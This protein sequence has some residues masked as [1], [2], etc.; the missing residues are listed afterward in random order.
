MILN[1]VAVLHSCAVKKLQNQSTFREQDC[2]CCHSF[3]SFRCNYLELGSLNRIT[4]CESSIEL[5]EFCLK[6][7]PYTLVLLSDCTNYV[8]FVCL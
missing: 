3:L 5:C 1:T 7:L 2:T 6:R 8:H 4:D